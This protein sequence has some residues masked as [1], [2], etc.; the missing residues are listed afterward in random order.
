MTVSTVRSVL[1]IKCPCYTSVHTTQNTNSV[2]A[3]LQQSPGKST[4]RGTEET[5]IT[6]NLI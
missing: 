1:E 2:G 6:R 3:A 4:R 5:A